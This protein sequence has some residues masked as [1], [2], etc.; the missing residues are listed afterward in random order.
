MEIQVDKAAT[1]NITFF[2]TRCPL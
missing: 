1:I 2:R